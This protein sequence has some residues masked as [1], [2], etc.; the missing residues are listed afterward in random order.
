[1]TAESLYVADG[2]RLIS[3]EYTRGPWSREHQHAGPPSA[4]LAR[5]IER[6]AGI[7]GGQLTRLSVDILR[8]VPIAPLQV[9]ARHL[10]PGRRVEQLE[11]TLTTDDGTELMRA[12]A[13]RMRFGEVD[14]EE[15]ADPPPAGP[16]GLSVAPR[17]RF[18]ADEI[19]YHAALEWRFI[20]GV[21]DEPGP[22]ACWTRMRV[23]L[24]SGEPTTPV[25]HLLV[26]GDAASGISAVLD[27][28]RYGFMNV[29]FTVHL[30]RPP[31]GDWLAMDAVTR[32]RRSGAGVC[33]S[34]LFDSGGRIGVTAQSLLVSDR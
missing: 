23:P 13:W 8:P 26:M 32:P 28:Q 18:F 21:F 27:W 7:E 29:D 11:A 10:R 6:T 25:E 4:L 3:T 34:V 33:T 31:R 20:H 22:A 1:V 17:P 9:S 14:L 16:D 19:A 30:E 12:V 24:V 2:D 15:P 5:A